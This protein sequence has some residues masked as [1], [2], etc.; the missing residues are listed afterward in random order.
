MIGLIDI[1]GLLPNLAL[2]KLSSYYKSLGYGVEFVKNNMVYEKI[3]ASSIFTC[4]KTKADALKN[5]YED[6]IVIGGTGWDLKRKL[7]YSI[8]TMRPDYGLYSVDMIEKKIRG[9]MTK[10]RKKKKAETIIDA[11]MGFTSR[12][13]IRNCKF[14]LVPQKEG[15]LQ[16]VADVDDL[17]RPG[18]DVLILHDNNLTASPDCVRVLQQIKK[19]KLVVDINQGIDIR[20]MNEEIAY[21]LANVK[22]LRSIHYAWDLMEYED[23]VIRGIKILLKYIKPSYHMCFV[24]VGFN[25]TFDEDKY[26][27]IKLKE[28]KVRPYIML[29]NN[30]GNEKMK[31]FRRWINGCI[32]KVCNWNEY[33]PW[34]NAQ[35]D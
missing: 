7:P 30:C 25:T 1:D 5:Q 10:E 3:F 16:T 31:H 14:C 17:V 29:Y 9:I 11:A 6:K 19:R 24:L 28:L 32:F 13:C 4:S 18:H 33:T 12:G 35:K 27:I 15:P 2:M 21:S 26:R 23:K 20:L 8:E 22:H 34:I